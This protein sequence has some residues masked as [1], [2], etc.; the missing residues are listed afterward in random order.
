MPRPSCSLPQEQLFDRGVVP[1]VAGQQAGVARNRG[2]RN[3][4]IK[5]AAAWTTQP[6]KNVGGL[7]G[8]FFPKRDDA[9][10]FQIAPGDRFLFRRAGP[11][12][13]SYRANALISISE[14]ESDI[15][16]RSSRSGPA[17]E[18]AFSR[19]SVSRTRHGADRTEIRVRAAKKQPGQLPGRWPEPSL[20]P[21]PRAPCA[22]LNAL[23]GVGA[24]DVAQTLGL[25]L[26]ELA[27]GL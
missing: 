10:A 13:N 20:V 12:Q 3:G 24:D 7:R 11:R 6:P 1:Q 5:G 19:K 21:P 2:R 14:G 25:L 16:R 15:E 17:L 27:L 9:I 26:G 23:Q 22:G 18:S 8:N 4:D